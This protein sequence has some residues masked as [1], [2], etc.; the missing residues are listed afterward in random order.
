M[1]TTLWPVAEIV[2]VSLRPSTPLAASKVLDAGPDCDC[3]F[4][5]ARWRR[6]L[7]DTLALFHRQTTVRSFPTREERTI[8]LG[9][10]Y[11]ST[12]WLD[13]YDTVVSGLLVSYE[14]VVFPVAGSVVAAWIGSGES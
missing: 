11:T 6:W 1:S 9:R 8:S 10:L 12:E 2:A 3:A 13:R 14:T 4:L 5:L 7:G